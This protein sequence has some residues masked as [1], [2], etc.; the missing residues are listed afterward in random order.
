MVEYD[1]VT[2]VKLNCNTEYNAEN[3]G[4]LRRI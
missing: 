3:S 2:N 1:M 4:K